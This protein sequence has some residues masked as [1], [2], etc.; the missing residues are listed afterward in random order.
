MRRICV[1]S[2]G[3][4]DYGLLFWPMR[5]IQNAPDLELQTIATGMH[6]APGFGMTVDRFAADGFPVSKQ[7]DMLLDSD[8][9]QAVSKSL[10]LAVIG[11]AEAYEQL[12]PDMVMLLGDRFEIMAA[13]QAALIARIPVAHLCGGDT[14][15]GAFDESIRHSITK[16]SHMHFVSNEESAARVIQMGE[17]PA[18]VHVV[19][20][21][22]LDAVHRTE[23]L[24]RDALFAT[25]GFEPARHNLLVTFHPV[26][27]GDV[28]SEAEFGE[29]LAALHTLGE[30]M[31]MIF[32]RSNADTG[33][34]LLNSM[35][36]KFLESHANAKSFDALGEQ[37]LSAMKHVDAVVG[38]SSSGLYEAPSFGIATV[39]I[40]DR[41]K[42]RLSA[43]SVIHSPADRCDIARSIW[44]AVCGDFSG[45]VNPY[46]DG[47]ASERI[48]EEIRSISDPQSLLQKHFF[49]QESN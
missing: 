36:D 11:F 20:S 22:G 23:L 25:I 13:A 8:S 7:I 16:M 29:L 34:R 9:V 46:G 32:T 19:G 4:P 28:A 41:Q 2:G 47:H 24:D 31:G 1:V 49:M 44:Q 38:N 6:L 17:N 39:N 21:P 26:T 48:I 15:E 37:Y 40:G 5:E 27:L 35:L 3:R 10:G 42:G 33:G 43:S 12:Q 30:E 45:T 18:H 14:T